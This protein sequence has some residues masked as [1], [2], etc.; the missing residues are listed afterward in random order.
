MAGIAG[1]ALKY[2]SVHIFVPQMEICSPFGEKTQE[3]FVY[4]RHLRSDRIPGSQ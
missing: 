4:K 1:M 2:N 3:R